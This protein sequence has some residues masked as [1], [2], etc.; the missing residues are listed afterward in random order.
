VALLNA[1]GETVATAGEPLH[2][3][4]NKLPAQGAR[5]ERGSL[6]VVNLVDFGQSARDD[7]TPNPPTVVISRS[8]EEEGRRRMRRLMEERHTT[9]TLAAGERRGLPPPFAPED[10]KVHLGPPAGEPPPAALEGPPEPRRRSR[11]PGDWR[12]EG[13]EREG[14]ASRAFFR[15]PFWM[16]QK[17]YEE[18]LAKRG[19]HGFVLVMSTGAMQ[20]ELAR[21][22]WLR[23]G[24]ALAALAAAAGL[25][26]GWR[27]LARATQCASASSARRR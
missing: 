2:V 7:G 3:D 19:L 18:L 22:L 17:H 20:A 9:E 8:E 27:G 12:P 4:V 10:D 6:M 21:D 24:V 26:L 14:R 16:D 5:W 11:E 15:R 13:E 25:G 1:A 23:L